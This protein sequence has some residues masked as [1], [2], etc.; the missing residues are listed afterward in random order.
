M[1]QRRIPQDLPNGQSDPIQ[2]F[3]DM[4]L[5]LFAERCAV[6][7][8]DLGSPDF[9]RLMCLTFAIEHL[10]PEPPPAP[11]PTKPRRWGDA[12]DRR[13]LESVAKKLGAGNTV[14]GAVKELVR[15]KVVSGNQNSIET[16]Y[17]EAKQRG[18]EAGA[19]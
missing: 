19:G 16:R 3:T 8:I 17:Y 10:L 5:R 15:A 4:V 7:K 18:R 1:P 9:W 12:E 14:R 13:L 6:Y 11:K 2:A